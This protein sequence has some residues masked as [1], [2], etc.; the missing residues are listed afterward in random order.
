MKFSKLPPPR[1][2]LPL[3]LTTESPVSFNIASVIETRNGKDHTVVLLKTD[4]LKG[5][6]RSLREDTLLPPHKA[7]GD[8]TVQVLAGHAEIAAADRT[9]LLRREQV[10]AL[11]AGVSHSVM[12]LGQSGIFITLAAAQSYCPFLD[13]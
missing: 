4:S 7:A 8:M 11:K 9:E 1:T 13:P 2:R 3:M 12:A 6:F 5:V 10:L